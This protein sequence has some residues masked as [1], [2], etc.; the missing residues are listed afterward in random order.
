MSA[1]PLNN[2]PEEEMSLIDKRR[3]WV[4]RLNHSGAK[5]AQSF[6]EPGRDLLAARNALGYRAWGQAFEK[7]EIKLDLTFA[8]RLM[9]AASNP[10]LAKEANLLYLPASPTALASLS[11]LSPENVELKIKEGLI[12]ADMT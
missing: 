12:S 9:K 11:K 7:G 6:L 2:S 5:T 1:N 4:E 3:Y 10:A 8:Q